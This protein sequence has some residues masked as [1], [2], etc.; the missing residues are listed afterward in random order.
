M[1][2]LEAREVCRTLFEHYYNAQ[3]PEETTRYYVEELCAGRMAA[4]DVQ[5]QIRDA[6]AASQQQQQKAAA[7]QTAQPAGKG[8]DRIEEYV[9]QLFVTYVGGKTDPVLRGML[10][11]NLLSGAY[12]LQ[13][14]EWAVQTSKEARAFA[15]EH[16][17]ARLREYVS[18]LQRNYFPRDGPLPEHDVARLVAAIEQK[19]MTLGDVEDEFKVR[20]LQQTLAGPPK[21]KRS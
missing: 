2:A 18:E 16:K 6:I 7:P 20:S 12:S 11:K 9:S 19:Q 4:D 21:T 17:R 3:P 14:A 15:V 10:V 8:K 13:E 1:D 5:Q